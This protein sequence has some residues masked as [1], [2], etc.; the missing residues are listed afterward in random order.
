MELAKLTRALPDGA[1]WSFE[2]KWDGFRALAF[3]DTGAIELWSRHE[4]PLGR[5]FPEVVDRLSTLRE[6]EL[7][8]DGEIIASNLDFPTLMAR[9]HPAASL[10]ARL[11]EETPAWFVAFDLLARH[12]RDLRNEPFQSRRAALVDLLGEDAPADRDAAVALAESTHDRD[13]ASQWLHGAPDGA[14]DGVVAK[15]DD[16]RYRPGARAML[17]VKRERTMDCVVGGVRL[18][19]DRRVVASLLLG[20]FDGDDLRHVGVVTSFARAQRAAMVRELA[21]FVTSLDDHPWR[22]GFALDGGPIGRLED[23]AG[24]RTPDLAQ[25]WTPLRP[26]LVCEVAY[27]PVD[28]ARLRHPASFRR[29]RPDR[30]ARSCTVDQLPSLSSTHA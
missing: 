15:A 23:A 17:K 26:E 30:T 9:V 22:D 28:G 19:L 7:V 25:D 3:V 13:L 11:A 2:P 29:W 21:P 6:R 4:R 8:L 10:V 14:V 12:G 16:L 20:L 1:C 24:W 18:A 5:Y 27:G